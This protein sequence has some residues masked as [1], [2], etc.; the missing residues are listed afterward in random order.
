M[1]ICK[2]Q[3]SCILALFKL[4]IF[5]SFQWR[6]T[7]NPIN[8]K[9]V[10]SLNSIGIWRSKC[11]F[12]VFSSS[13][14]VH[15]VCFTLLLLFYCFRYHLECHSK[16]TTNGVDSHSAHREKIII[17]LKWRWGWRGG[18]VG[19][20]VMTMKKSNGRY[21]SEIAIFTFCIHVALKFGNS[22]MHTLTLF[23]SLPTNKL[24]RSPNEGNVHS[25]DGVIGLFQKPK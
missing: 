2:C 19:G 16:D 5:Y 8:C 14:S 22:T 3:P 7:P 20:W 4:G 1:R 9:Y 24:M 11:A 6:H 25:K 12:F 17:S 18:D 21:K 13:Y 23:V 10:C 15:F